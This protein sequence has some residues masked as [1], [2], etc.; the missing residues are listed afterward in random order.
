MLAR[1]KTDAAS[2]AEKDD[3]AVKEKIANLC[4]VV[5][6]LQGSRERGMGGEGEGEAAGG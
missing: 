4:F 6:T 2:C 5:S 1:K 3:D